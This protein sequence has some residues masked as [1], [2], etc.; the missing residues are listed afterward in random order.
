MISLNGFSQ[1]YILMTLIPAMIWF[2]RLIL[3]SPAAPIFILQKIHVPVNK[4]IT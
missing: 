3:L 2:I 1:Q 4:G